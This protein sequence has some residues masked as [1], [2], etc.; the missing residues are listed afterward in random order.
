[1]AHLGA[2]LGSPL[3]AQPP[4]L[5]GVPRV[6]MPEGVRGIG[7]DK[8]QVVEW[9]FAASHVGRC[10]NWTHPSHDGDFGSGLA[11]REVAG[12]GGAPTGAGGSTVTGGE[13]V[14]R[15]GPATY[16]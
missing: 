4:A 1:M 8:G 5:D 11:R 16:R 10:R 15:A 12:R 9:R 3:A 13:H 2:R 7:L 6:A 14:L